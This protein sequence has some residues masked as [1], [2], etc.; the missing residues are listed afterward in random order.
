MNNTAQQ[1]LFATTSL[2]LSSKQPVLRD[3]VR[4]SKPP[5]LWDVT[6]NWW[7]NLTLH[8]L[9]EQQIQN[10]GKFEC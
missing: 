8:Y 3:G 10:D 7:Y 9:E 1:L 6:L 2:H 4:H 5:L